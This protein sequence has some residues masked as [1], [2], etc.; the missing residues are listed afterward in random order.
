MSSRHTNPD[1]DARL[2]QNFLPRGSFATS[3]IM[4]YG[5]CNWVDYINNAAAASTEPPTRSSA[6]TTPSKPTAPS[7]TN[8]PSRNKQVHPYMWQP[9]YPNSVVN[10][11]SGGDA[12]V[13]RSLQIEQIRNL[14]ALEE[15]SR[16]RA[17]ELR[18]QNQ[19]LTVAYT[20]LQ[21]QKLPVG[22]PD[23]TPRH[24]GRRKRSRRI[25]TGPE[26]VEREAA[27]ARRLVASEVASEAAQAQG[28]APRLAQ[29]PILPPPPPY[30]P[31]TPLHA[32][33]KR[34]REAVRT[35]EKPPTPARVAPTLRLIQEEKEPV[36]EMDSMEPPP[37]TAPAAV[38]RRSG[39]Q[40]QGRGWESLVPKAR[41]KK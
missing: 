18:V 20:Y 5:G 10:T 41:G 3:V 12:V 37:S 38:G 13:E 40:G 32:P 17:Q 21:L 24:P 27:A 34:D 28:Y 36:P 29:L 31:T 2:P 25:E 11:Y 8:S 39:R 14:L 4:A 6:P 23:V 19:L 26:R 35:P 33:A 9:A 30:R 22:L 15:A 1:V 16:F 7:P